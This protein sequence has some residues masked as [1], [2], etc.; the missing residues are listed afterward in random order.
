M[1]ETD[2]TTTEHNRNER[3]R[4]RPE[5]EHHREKTATDHEKFTGDFTGTY[6]YP[7]SDSDRYRPVN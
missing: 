5:A 2:E 7:R 4:G 3:D 6:P 1:T